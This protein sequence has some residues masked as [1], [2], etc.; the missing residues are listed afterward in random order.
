MDENIFKKKITY[1]SCNRG[2]KETDLLLGNFTK[3]NINSMNIKQLKML[4]VLLDEPDAE[5]FAWI[6]KKN[7][8]PKKHDNEVMIMLQNFKYR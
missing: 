1:K 4:D 6:T 8:T 7:S 2:W 5:I 3:Q